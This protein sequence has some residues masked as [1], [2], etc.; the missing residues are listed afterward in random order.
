MLEK[1]LLFR[2]EGKET[3]SCLPCAG[4]RMP[5]IILLFER[6]FVSNLIIAFHPAG[7]R[8]GV[9]FMDSVNVN[10]HSLVLR[11]P[12]P[13][14]PSWTRKAGDGDSPLRILI[15]CLAIPWKP[16]FCLQK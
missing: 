13:L 8:M 4:I 12:S 1:V 15:S 10:S 16:I 14:I 11:V 2:P 7:K 5:L 9:L 6:I 3:I